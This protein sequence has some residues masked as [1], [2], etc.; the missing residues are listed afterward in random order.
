MILAIDILPQGPLSVQVGDLAP[1]DIVAPKAVTYESQDRT[2]A[3]RQAA[4][5]AVPFQYDFT[6]DKAIAIAADQVAAF[7]TR[8]QA[9]RLD[10]RG[11]HADRL[12]D[13]TA[14]QRGQ[15]SAA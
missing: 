14:A 7:K 10:V 6:S 13:G 5:A 11:E 4:R 8:V 12:P 15:R 2:D 1:R 3:A 9:G